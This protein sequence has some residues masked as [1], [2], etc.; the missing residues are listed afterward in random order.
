MLDDRAMFCLRYFFPGMF[1]DNIFEAKVKAKAEARAKVSDF[2]GQ[3]HCLSRPRPRVF[4]AMAKA[5]A[6]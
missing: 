2:Q 1:E 5:S 3:G 6:L 4:D